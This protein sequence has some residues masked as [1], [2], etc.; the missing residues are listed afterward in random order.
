MTGTGSQKQE[1]AGDGDGE[2]STDLPAVEQPDPDE[3]V[4][5]DCGEHDDLTG[6]RQDELIEITCGVCACRWQRD[7]ERRC[8]RC[9]AGDLYAAPVAVIEKSRG[10]Q[11]SIVST[12]SE[13]LCWTCDR[14]L[15][16]DQRQSGTA[17]MPDQLPTL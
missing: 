2:S 11:L 1:C 3:I 16:D 17:L 7:P 15:I 10:S 13:Y 9:G 12:R 14:D 6:E 4:C 5:P 8:P